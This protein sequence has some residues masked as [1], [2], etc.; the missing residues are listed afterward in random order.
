METKYGF[1]QSGVPINDFRDACLADRDNKVFSKACN[2]TLSSPAVP[3][4][5]KRDN[6]HSFEIMRSGLIALGYF[7]LT[8][9]VLMLVLAL[10]MGVLLLF[11]AL[12]SRKRVLVLGEDSDR[13]LDRYLDSY[14]LWPL[15]MILRLYAI[16]LDLIPRLCLISLDLMTLCGVFVVLVV[17]R[18]PH[19]LKTFWKWSHG[20]WF[21]N[22]NSVSTSA[23]PMSVCR[24]KDSLQTA[25]TKHSGLDAMISVL[26]EKTKRLILVVIMRIV[27][28]M[29]RIV[30]ISVHFICILILTDRL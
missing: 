9:F 24:T 30:W 1:F 18:I 5:F 20:I 2:E 17:P 13:H 16:P 22:N 3:P 23:A 7:V 6:Q 28:W 10:M 8:P 19:Y 25:C 15:E 11:R 29:S 14:I 12:H 27:W 26:K 4:P 21:S